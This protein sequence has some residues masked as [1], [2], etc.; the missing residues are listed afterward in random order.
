MSQ[1]NQTSTTWGSQAGYVWSLIGSAVGFAN[2][3]SF[4][5]QAYK[6]GGGAFLIP[7]FFALFLLGIP[8]LMLEGAIG[9]HWKLPLVDAYN[10]VWGRKGKL[11]GWLAVFACLT[12]GGFYIVLTGYSAAYVYF[13]ATGS[14]PA[15]AKGFFLHEFLQTSSSISEWGSFSWKIFISTAVVIVLTWFILVRNVKDGIE[16]VCSIFMPLLVVVV[17]AFAV[18]AC[19]LP[20]GSQA[21]AYYLTPDFSRLLDP[22]LWRDVFGQLFFSLSLGLGIIIGYSRHTSKSVD[23]GKAM[24]YTALGDFTVSFIAGLAIFAFLAHVSY[25]QGIPFDQILQSDSSFD[26]GF[27]LFPQLLKTLGPTLEQLVGTLFFFS[28]FIA[29]ITGVFSIVESIAGNVEYSQGSKRSTAVTVTLAALLLCATFFCF[30]NAGYIID[31]LAPMVMGTNMLIGGLALIFAFAFASKEMRSI[32]L[33]RRGSR[34]SLPAI[35]LRYIVPGLLIVILL[36]SIW[37]EFAGFDTFKAVRWGWFVFA[38]VIAACMARSKSYSDKPAGE[39]Q[40]LS[41]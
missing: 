24:L 18:V 27:I 21:F 3:L 16:R 13:S 34:L 19:L 40:A 32:P 38:L 26:I 41:F 23:I 39:Q 1:P 35:S 31:A 11:L 15:D 14:I 25:S 20:G 6:N 28:L 17:V 33:W 10:N 8:M 2:L 7:Y 36:G 37:Q 29:G 12:I 4:S 30:G 9:H 22:T 5:A